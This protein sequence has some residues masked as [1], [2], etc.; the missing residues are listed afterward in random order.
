MAGALIFSFRSCNKPVFL[1]NFEGKNRFIKKS[2]IKLYKVDFFETHNGNYIY[3][4]DRSII[5]YVL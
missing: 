4:F 3:K 2:F 5:S 1:Y